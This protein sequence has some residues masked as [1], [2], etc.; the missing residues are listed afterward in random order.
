MV[1]FRVSAMA[2]MVFGIY[3]AVKD[4]RID[5]IEALPDD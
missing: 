5:P 1:A 4:A 3:P 2:G